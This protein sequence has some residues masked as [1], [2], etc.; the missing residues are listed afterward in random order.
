MND[1]SVLTIESDSGKGRAFIIVAEPEAQY[2]ELATQLAERLTP[3]N[4]I[5]LIKTPFVEAGN[6]RELTGKLLQLLGEKGIRQ[7]SFIALGEASS[8]VQSLALTDLKLVRTL[9]LVNAST[10]PHPTRRARIIRKLEQWLPLGLPFRSDIEGFDSKPLLQRIRC[11]V[12]IVST[13]GAG[14]YFHAQADELARGLPT[15]W[16][17]TLNSSEALSE[18]SDAIEDFQEIPAKCPQK[19]ALG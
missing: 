11:P 15:A 7:A 9:I 16:Q 14:K 18:L 2:G 13:V 17:L 12:L 10:R 4:R 19:A 3:R 5:V 8:I 1:R 6:W